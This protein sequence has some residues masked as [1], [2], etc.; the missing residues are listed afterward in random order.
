MIRGVGGPSGIF[1][2]VPQQAQ[3]QPPGS[4]GTFG[5]ALREALSRPGE[6]VFSR[7]ARERLAQANIV[8]D[9]EDVTAI[10]SA[11]SR[12]GAGGARESLILMD[13]V[14]FVVSVPNRTVITVVEADRMRENVFTN[15]DSTVIVSGR[16]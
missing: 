3:R 13:D 7:H 4:D 16:R 14:A 15:I 8:L 11:V 10:S 2:P 1:R 12:A 9:G 6:L 5:A